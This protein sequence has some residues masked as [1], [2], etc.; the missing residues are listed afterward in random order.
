MYSQ[1]SNSIQ[2]CMEVVNIFSLF[3][4]LS[5][6]LV[7]LVT[8]TIQYIPSDTHRMC[9]CT[10]RCAYCNIV[11]YDT[12]KERH[13][14]TLKVI[15]LIFDLLWPYIFICVLLIVGFNPFVQQRIQTDQ[16]Q[17]IYNEQ[18]YHPNDNDYN[19]L[20]NCGITIFVFALAPRTELLFF[21][22]DFVT[23]SWQND[24]ITITI[25]KQ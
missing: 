21:A 2:H 7:L 3:A 5:L 22:F 11:L 23:H 24:T 13:H 6:P 20:Y 15:K 10:G 4:N 25:Y 18:W 12:T 17:H 9:W 8:N 1:K 16:E 19:H 14:I